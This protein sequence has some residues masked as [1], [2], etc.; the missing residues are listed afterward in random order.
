MIE[1]RLGPAQTELADG[2]FWILG[3]SGAAAS[4][5]EIFFDGLFVEG[6]SLDAI[7]A[8]SY[9]CASNINE[10]LTFVGAYTGY[11]YNWNLETFED[12]SDGFEL[13]GFEAQC[14]TFTASDGTKKLIVAGGDPGVTR[15]QILDIETRTWREGPPLPFPIRLGRVFQDENTFFIFGGYNTAS[16]SQEKGER[17]TLSSE[18]QFMFLIDVNSDAFCFS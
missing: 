9:L 10:E 12:V 18:K 11:L 6:P 3:G 17:K 7:Q 4:T 15:T 16:F 2:S 8:N 13:D 5:S 1:G 14:G